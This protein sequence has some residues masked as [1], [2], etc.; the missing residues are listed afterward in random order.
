MMETA[1]DLC[2][3]DS[4]RPDYC[5]KQMN[6]RFQSTVLFAVGLFLS[7]GLAAPLSAQDSSANKASDAWRQF[8]GPT[9]MGVSERG[10]KQIE[11]DSPRWRTPLKGVGWSSPVTDGDRIWV[12]AAVTTEASAE[13]KQKKLAGVQFSQMKDVAGSVEVLVH[14]VDVETGDVVVSRS[15]GLIDDPNP[16]HPMNSYASPTA[17]IASGKV[18]CHFGSYGTWCLDANTGETLWQRKLVVDDSVGPGSSPTIVDGIVVLICDGIDQQFVA[19]LDLETGETKW[20]TNRPAMRTSNPEYKKAYSTPLLIEIDGKKQVVAVGAQWVC[21]YDPKSGEEIWRFDHGSGFSTT[22][23]PILVDGS[24]VF[25]T[26]YMRPELVAIDPSGQGDITS[27]NLLWRSSRGIPAKPS[28]V[29]NG[30]SVYLISDGGVASSLSLKDGSILWQKRLGGSY[31]A[32]PLMYGS[33]ILV[34]NHEGS[35]HVFCDDEGYREVT[36]Y[37]FGEQIMSSPIPFEDGLLIRTK[38]AIYRY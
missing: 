1:I 37:D 3:D 16:I 24:L 5:T 21:G 35:L 30:K 33:Q 2:P 10:L 14:S 25:S 23:M 20:K 31:S 28:P 15:L 17:A 36:K 11:F 9:G 29:S 27:T 6:K 18:V 4:L 22:P 32:S 8:R 38:S 26:G 34:G 7:F 13:E 12:T 19:G